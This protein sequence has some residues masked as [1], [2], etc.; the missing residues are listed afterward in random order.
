MRQWWSWSASLVF[1]AG[2]VLAAAPAWGQGEGKTLRQVLSAEN[3]PL[4]PETLHN[5][6]KTITSGAELDDATEFVI[7]YMLY[8]PSERLNPPLF[9]DQF[10]R[11]T[12]R[13]RSARFGD[14]QGRVQEI[15][16]ECSGSVLS[17]TTAGR[18]LILD[19]HINPSAG[20]LL[21]ISPNLELEASVY[22][23]LV[24]RLGED[25]LVY[26]RSETHSA[27]VH[28]AEIALY[29]LRTK[30][31]T[32]IF[33]RKPDQAI[34]SARIAQ[35]KE[36]YK[37][38]ENWC[39]KWDDPC[40]PESFDSELSS[41]VKTN[42]AEHALAFVISYEQIQDYPN[43]EAKP[44]GPKEVVYVYRH[45]NDEK[46]M[47]WR[48]MLWSDVKAKAGDVSLGRLLDRLILEKILGV[49]TK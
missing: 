1:A 41:D 30:R 21:V 20:C 18:R 3:L 13:W 47:E 42:E 16:G 25:E 24:G 26:E 9:I 14:A 7:A 4:D 49:E 6:D 27:P 46:K 34:R 40:D 36:F 38:R 48:E 19:T 15:D 12:R 11:H 8:E 17:I 39:Q 33:P 10:D 5:L 22:G 23:W 2:M 29:D 28:S 31:D 44:S 37:T 45:V 32:T 35:L 43:D